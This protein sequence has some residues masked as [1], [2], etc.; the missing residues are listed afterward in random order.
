MLANLS[1][2]GGI[3][4]MFSQDEVKKRIT[5]L[6]ENNSNQNFSDADL[7]ISAELISNRLNLR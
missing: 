5:N 3:Y 2:T 6:S 7:K 4:G 1:V